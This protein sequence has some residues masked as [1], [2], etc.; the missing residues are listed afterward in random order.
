MWLVITICVVA[1]TVHYVNGKTIA[2]ATDRQTAVMER[3]AA[4]LENKW[5]F[6]PWMRLSK[7]NV[8]IPKLT[9][10]KSGWQIFKTDYNENVCWKSYWAA[11]ISLE[12][13]I[14][15]NNV[16]S[17]SSYYLSLSLFS[18]GTANALSWWRHRIKK[19]FLRLRNRKKPFFFGFLIF[20]NLKWVLSSTRDNEERWK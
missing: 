3:L 14:M 9:G 1:A 12:E 18:K 6:C 7:W 2:S 16:L 17:L 4:L 8:W 10:E 15:K 19:G 20:D 11:Y 13:K 5:T